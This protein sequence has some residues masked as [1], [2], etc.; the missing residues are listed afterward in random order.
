[1]II[2]VISIILLLLVLFAISHVTHRQET[3]EWMRK[4]DIEDYQSS[5][6]KQGVDPDDLMR[7]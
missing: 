6:Y 7:L 1:M 4:Q 5:Q 3:I 2:L